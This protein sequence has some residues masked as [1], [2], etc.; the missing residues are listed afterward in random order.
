M[1]EQGASVQGQRCFISEAVPACSG[2]HV[3]VCCTSIIV[4]HKYDLQTV[5]RTA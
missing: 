5:G 4:M 1:K 2:R 3:I